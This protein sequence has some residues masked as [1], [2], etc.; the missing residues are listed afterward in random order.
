MKGE[1]DESASD[2]ERDIAILD[3]DTFPVMIKKR[4]IVIAAMYLIGK[5]DKP[6]HD[7]ALYV[8][9]FTSYLLLG[10]NFFYYSGFS[11][12]FYT[13]KWKINYVFGMNLSGKSLRN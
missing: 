8:S 1:W 9:K 3:D 7:D 12:R 11:R 13:S 6:T 2:Q 5:L 4:A 10:F